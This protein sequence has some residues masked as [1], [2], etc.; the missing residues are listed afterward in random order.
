MDR[1]K[2]EYKK[3]GEVAEINTFT[4]VSHVKKI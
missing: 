1:S 4:K 2:W 3:L